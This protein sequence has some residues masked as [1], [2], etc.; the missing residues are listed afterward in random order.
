MSKSKQKGTAFEGQVAAY[1]TEALGADIE[2][3][4]LGGTNDRGDI[5][6]VTVGGLRA[7]VECKAC[8]T[9]AIPQWL[10]EAEAER[11]NDGAD[12][13]FVVSKRRGVGDKNTGK[14]LVLM[15]LA[16]LCKL[17]NAANGKGQE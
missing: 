13:G 7:V 11:V 2:R 4:A 1:M 9:L 3:R 16:T 10:R 5:A 17:I 12:Y 15:D 6:G 14:Q 8:K